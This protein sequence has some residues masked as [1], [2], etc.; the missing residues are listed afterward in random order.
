MNIT[1]S[2][3][4][5]RLIRISNQI[6]LL[7][8]QVSTNHLNDPTVITTLISKCKWSMARI[9]LVKAICYGDPSYLL[10][11]TKMEGI[12]KYNSPTSNANRGKLIVRKNLEL[13]ENML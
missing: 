5:V 2:I 12:M 11:D 8:Y 9:V 7:C 13:A 3:R 10:G 6:L 1:Y 4:L